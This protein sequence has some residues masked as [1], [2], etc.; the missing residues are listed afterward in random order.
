MNG[1]K[2][3]TLGHQE[4]RLPVCL[5]LCQLLAS[6]GLAASSN[7]YDMIWTNSSVIS[8]IKFQIMYTVSSR[9]TVAIAGMM[10]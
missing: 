9:T 3:T 4:L 1:Q 8:L 7:V 5:F 6:L 10:I 2:A